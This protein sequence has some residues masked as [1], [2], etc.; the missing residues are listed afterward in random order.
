MLIYILKFVLLIFLVVSCMAAPYDKHQSGNFELKII[1]E[2]NN[3]DNPIYPKVYIN[4]EFVGSATKEKPVLYLRK[5]THTIRV[6]AQ[7]FEIYE[8]KIK[9][10]GGPNMQSLIV[11]LKLRK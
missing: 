10:L 2:L 9:I 7:G 5:G 6:E 1:P 11:S 4:K 3:G 8:E